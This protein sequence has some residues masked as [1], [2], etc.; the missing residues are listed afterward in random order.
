MKSIRI[1][2]EVWLSKPGWWRNTS[3]RKGICSGLPFLPYELVLVIR[4]LIVLSNPFCLVLSICPPLWVSTETEFFTAIFHSW[5]WGC[6]VVSSI[7]A[8]HNPDSGAVPMTT[9]SELYLW[10]IQSGW[11][12]SP[13]PPEKCEGGWWEWTSSCLGVFW[14][15][16]ALVSKEEGMRGRSWEEQQASSWDCL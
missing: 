4:L 1:T 7:N 8:L 2:R 13:R 15:K 11:T 16:R 10:P 5:F 14:E 9:D 3:L 6:P 12:L